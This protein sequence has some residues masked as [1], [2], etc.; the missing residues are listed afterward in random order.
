MAIEDLGDD[1]WRR[2]GMMERWGSGREKTWMVEGVEV[3]GVKRGWVER[4]ESVEERG[5]E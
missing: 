4:C 5:G 3:V 1:M 2:G